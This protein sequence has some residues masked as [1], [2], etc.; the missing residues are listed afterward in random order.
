MFNFRYAGAA[1]LLFT[2]VCAGLLYGQETRGTILGRVQD[3][4]GAIIEGAKVSATNVATGVTVAAESGTTGDFLLPFLLPGTYS[5]TAHQQGFKQVSRTGIVVRL[6]EKVTVNVALELGLTT[7]KVSVVA[8]SPLLQVATAVAGEVIDNKRISE[9]PLK[10]GNPIML[11]SLAPGVTNLTS[12]G[13]GRSRPFDNISVSSVSVNGAAS[14]SN[15]FTMDGA[16]NTTQDRIG[17]VPPGDMVQEFKIV[18]AAFDATVGYTPGAVINVSLKSGTNQIHGTTYFF[19]QNT[20]F[21]ANTFFNNRDGKDRIPTYLDRWGVSAGGPILLPKIYNGRNRT[22]WQYGYEALWDGTPESPALLTVPTDSEKRGDFSQL[23]ALGPQYQIYD[24]ATIQPNGNGTFT[25]QPFPGNIIPSNRLSPVAAKLAELWSPPNTAGTADGSNN[26]NDPGYV[27]DRYYS[28]LMRFDHAINDKH[29]FFVRVSW[30]KNVNVYEKRFNDANGANFFRWNKG[31]AIDDVYVFSPKLL[32]NVRYGFNRFRETNDPLSRAFDPASFGF[33][34]GFIDQVRKIDPARVTLPEIAV[35]GYA[36]LGNQGFYT[37]RPEVH[38]L[39]VLMTQTVGSHTLR[40]GW[41]GRLYRQNDFDFGRPSG[42]LAFGTDWTR[43]PLNTSGSS[44][45]GQ[46]L[47][48]FLVGLPTG[49]SMAVNDTSA[50]QST[51]WSLYL[52][53]DWKVTAKLTLNLGIRYEYETPITERFNRSVRGF[54]FETPI[55][56]E[57]AVRANYAS[58][59]IPQVPVSQFRAVGGLQ[60]ANVNGQPRTLWNADK[61]NFLPRIGFA[62]A[63]GSTMAIRGGYGIFFDQLGLSRRRINATGFSRSTDL[64]PSL[65]NGQTFS[66]S[67]ANPFPGGFDLPVG[68]GLGLMT[69]AGQG[70]SFFQS[71]LVNP[72][73]QRWE[74]SV[75]R[76]VG[77]NS[78]VEV[79]Y[80]G[81]RGTKL[82]M[83]RNLDAVPEAYFSRSPVR[84]QAAIDFQGA[85]VANPFYPLLPRTG[86]AGTTV[87]RSQ[88]LRPYPQFTSVSTQNNQGY[89]WYHAL[90]ARLERRFSGGITLNAAFTHSK[91]MEATGLLNEFDAVPERVISASDRPNRLAVSGIYELPFG[92]GRRFLASTSSIVNHLASGWQFSGL[93]EW[94][95]GAALGFGNAIFIGDVKEIPLPISERT[96]SRWF[97]TDAGFERNG[98]RQLGAN[99]RFLPSRF[100]GLRSDGVSNIDASIIKNTY[101]TESVRVQLRA[102]FINAMNHTQFAAPNTSPT[103]GAFGQVSAI[104]RLPR[105]IQF[106]LKVLF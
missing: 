43:G 26:Y 35:A 105:V 50:Q 83:S 47:A 88:L 19:N 20:A 5:L 37:I 81:N 13:M 91:L 61:N 56:I 33:A 96:W 100:S 23:L 1:S 67:I 86:L 14:L 59:P 45:I 63:L 62:Y 58:N 25:R 99:V 64:V 53:D 74:L 60:F 44:P 40:Y 82:R 11:A 71:N 72:Y 28:H 29:R 4:S 80:V 76:T 90:Q 17:F 42:S 55:P 36:P 84:D 21:N 87:P 54:D 95:S 38:D 52:Q 10:D 49:G 73:T 93:Y 57:A 22:F 98:G 18:S 2:C 75:Q 7:E 89:S 106:G 41:G 102:E 12:G 104:S 31:L 8:E 46:G 34:S 78:V 51:V 39:T 66:A 27:T 77:R 6:N 68:A 94:Q 16:P 15:D 69:S 3:P 70:I 24:P 9:L 85:A 48:S 30:N 101:I 32:L 103:S 79:M 92:R 65:D 97:N